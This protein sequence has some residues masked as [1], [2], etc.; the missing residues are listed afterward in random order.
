VALALKLAEFQL[1]EEFVG[2]PPVILLDDVMSDLDDLRR[3]QLLRWLD[4][5]CQSFITCTNLR[6]FPPEILSG[7]ATFR[8]VAG[9]ITQ[10]SYEEA[11][12]R[13]SAEADEPTPTQAG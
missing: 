5:R 4:R 9:T 13:L 2:E 11:Q 10:D 8:V 3:R 6:S 7:A 1:I 12:S